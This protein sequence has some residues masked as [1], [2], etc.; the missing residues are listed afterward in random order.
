MPQASL[1]CNPS[2]FQIA[3]SKRCQYWIFIPCNRKYSQSE[4]RKAVNIVYLLLLLCS[5]I[6]LLLHVASFLDSSMA[7]SN[8]SFDPETSKRSA[9]CLTELLF[10][11]NTPQLSVAVGSC[12]LTLSGSSV[13]ALSIVMS[14][15]HYVHE[16]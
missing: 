15:G 8:T 5:D 3:P 4:H 11:G 10:D 9:D 7:L 6:G 2:D 13:V 16:H 12:Q 1:S 14:L